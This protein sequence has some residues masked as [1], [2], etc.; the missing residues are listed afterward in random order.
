MAKKILIVGGV[1]GG[2]TTA[3]RSRR[4][5]EQ[6]EIIMFERGPHV[7]FAN[8]GL[9]YYVGEII[10]QEK[11]LLLATPELFKKRFNVDVR[12]Q[13]EV[14]SIDREKRQ[15]S[16]KDLQSG[17]TYQESYDALVLSPGASP[18][19][20]AL[21][22]I[23]LPGIFTLRNIPDSRQIKQWI[24]AHQ[25][26]QAVVVGAGFIGVEM[27]ENLRH[28]G[29]EVDLIEAASQILP[30]FD[31]EMMSFAQERLIENGIRL[32]LGQAVAGFEK[33]EE[34]RLAV[35]TADRTLHT[36]MVI[37]AIGVRPDA[38]LAKK[39]GLEIG[40]TGG[41]KVD[42]F[43]RTQDPNIW[44]V[45]DAVEVTD[46][47][48]GRPALIPLAGPANR[49]G[50]IAAESIAGKP[51]PYRGTLGTAV[52]GFFGMTAAATGASEKTLKKHGIAYEK[53]YLYPGDHAGYYPGANP[54]YMKLLFDPVQGKVLGLQAVGDSGVEK[55]VD[56][57][58]MAILKGA[59]VEDLEEA[60]LSYAPQFGSAKDPVNLAGFIAANH[61]RGDLPLARWEDVSEKN[62]FLLDVR[63]IAEFSD[64]HVEGAMNIPLGEL[65]DRMDELPRHQEVWVYCAAGQRSYYAVR[66]LLQRGVKA[67]QL[68]GGYTAWWSFH[69]S[70]S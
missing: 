3:A 55:R 62:P 48:T 51:R 36:D 17:E 44:A 13:Q 18:I 39:A 29:L 22:G 61:R 32:H 25:A 68:P 35:R 56:V 43:M 33:W 24:A 30:P 7:S 38:G 28:L 42:A 5:D 8:C 37:L 15:V 11:K 70:A 34:D 63:E 21:P 40:V 67:R 9:P 57:V 23:D 1:A 69:P 19:R 45:G 60:E 14:L 12:V 20:P 16:V 65:R 47:V 4:L 10:P 2:A 54:I 58:A 49:Q 66:Q 53:A 31:P 26:K 27:A 59:T 64:G 50:R 46:F 6:A 52:V 41:I